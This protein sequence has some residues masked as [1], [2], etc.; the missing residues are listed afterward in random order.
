MLMYVRIQQE[1]L[2]FVSMTILTC[3]TKQTKK[4]N[5]YLRRKEVS[6]KEKTSTEMS[7]WKEEIWKLKVIMA[8]SNVNVPLTETCDF[9]L[10]IYTLCPA[11]C[12]I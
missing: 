6:Y 10:G 4:E 9:H 8:G 3:D 7:T 12:M 2:E 5:E 1:K 11:S